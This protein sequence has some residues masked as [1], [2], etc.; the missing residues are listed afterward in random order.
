MNDWS[1]GQ[2]NAANTRIPYLSSLVSLNTAELDPQGEM[3][4]LNNA[5]ELVQMAV[6]PMNEPI[7]VRGEK[8]W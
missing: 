6:A 5:N 2:T 7:I 4:W 8:D 1:D 3:E